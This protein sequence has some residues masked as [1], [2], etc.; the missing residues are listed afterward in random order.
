M[1]CGRARKI[2]N[3]IVYGDD[4]TFHMVGPIWVGCKAKQFYEN[5]RR[6]AKVSCERYDEWGT[7]SPILLKYK[8]KAQ[9]IP[10]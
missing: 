10:D 5:R 8:A 7:G 4:T 3:N 2:I 9:Y 1:K 6:T